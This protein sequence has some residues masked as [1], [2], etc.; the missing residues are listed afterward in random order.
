VAA[1]AKFLQFLSRHGHAAATGWRF[2]SH[3]SDLS[4]HYFRFGRAIHILALGANLLWLLLGLAGVAATIFLLWRLSGS[5]A[6]GLRTVAFITFLLCFAPLHQAFHLG[7]SALLV[8]PAVLW[9][10]LLAE[11]EQAWQAGL[12]LGIAA[13]LKPQIAIWVLLYYLL[14]GRKQV[15]VGA[16]ATGWEQIAGTPYCVRPSESH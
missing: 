12:V 11:K 6:W 2:G 10:I 4:T 13:C 5:R 16:L 14:S 7:N 3:C 1:R 15:F 8:V 9:A